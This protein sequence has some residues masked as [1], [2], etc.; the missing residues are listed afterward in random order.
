[1]TFSLIRLFQKK[2][3]ISD[4]LKQPEREAIAELLL[5]CMYADKFIALEEGKFIEDVAATLNWE[6]GTTFEYFESRAT[7]QVRE[8][9]E[10]ADVREGFFKT[11][12][13]RLSSPHARALALDLAHQL[14]LA[15]GVEAE[16]E[17]QLEARLK[18]LLG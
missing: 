9:N 12:R 13:D 15:D 16:Q 2:A 11:I 7:A 8:A 18:Q 5:F 1:M 14:F 10:D 4:G 3:K 17:R 6:S